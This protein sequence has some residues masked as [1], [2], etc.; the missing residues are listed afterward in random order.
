MSGL[1]ATGA[2]QAV[3]RALHIVL[4]Y[5]C[6]KLCCMGNSKIVIHVYSNYSYK[7]DMQAAIGAITDIAS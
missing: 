5:V 7:Q 1:L 4:L 6:E 3:P 2:V